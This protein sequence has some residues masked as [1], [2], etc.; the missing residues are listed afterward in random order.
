MGGDPLALGFVNSKSFDRLSQLIIQTMLV[1]LIISNCDKARILLP[2]L[3][4]QFG[5]QVAE[6]RP[7]LASLRFICDFISH[8]RFHEVFYKK[9]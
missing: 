1:L 4:Y 7:R 5:I 6:F 3:G 2:S 9:P 8:I